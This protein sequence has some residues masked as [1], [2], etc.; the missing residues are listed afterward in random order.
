MVAISG[1]AVEALADWLSPIAVAAFLRS[2]LG[3]FP[4]ARPAAATSYLPFLTWETLE[5]VLRHPEPI[6]AITVRY[7]LLVECPCPRSVVEVR[8]Q[9]QAGVSV[10]IRAAERHEPGLATLASSFAR[11]LPGE[12]HVQLYATPAGTNSF[13]W[14]FDFEDVFIVQTL[15][16][17]EYYFRANTVA[18][19]TALGEPMDVSRVRD[20][21]SPLMTARLEAGDWLYIPARWWH[22]VKCVEESLSISIGVMSPDTLRAAKRVPRGWSGL[23][24]AA[25]RPLPYSEP[26]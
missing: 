12:V 4:Y 16:V 21:T 10:V 25:V 1:A 23:T 8:E 17:K 11:T 22:L 3:Q 13:G 19:E 9:M 14:H 5:R 6:D 2:H 7:G 15:G 18:L 26:R 24:A 20:E